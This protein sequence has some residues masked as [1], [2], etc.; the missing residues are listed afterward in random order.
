LREKL[1]LTVNENRVLRRMFGPMDGVT[2]KLR[3][4]HNEELYDVYLPN[5]IWIVKSGIIRWAGHVAGMGDR[6]VGHWV[7]VG[8]PEGKIRFGRTI[9]RIGK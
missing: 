8:R 2:G 4:L 7:L 5:T 1:K 6:R 3:R 9:S